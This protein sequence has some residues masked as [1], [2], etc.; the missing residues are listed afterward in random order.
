MFSEMW[1]IHFFVWR[2]T[3][4]KRNMQTEIPNESSRKTSTLCWTRC[5]ILPD[6]YTIHYSA[7]ATIKHFFS[8]ISHLFLRFQLYFSFR[9]IKLRFLWLKSK[10]RGGGGGRGSMNWTNLEAEW[11]NHK[12]SWIV[13]SLSSLLFDQTKL[14]KAKYTCRV[15]NYT[16]KN[17]HLVMSEKSITLYLNL[18]L[19]N[20]SISRNGN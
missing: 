16:L 14:K 9:K 10:G 1:R 19:I 2:N 15:L 5:W 12:T 13:E 7:P 6:Y 20:E 4:C 3:R 17:P 8:C 11:N 18:A